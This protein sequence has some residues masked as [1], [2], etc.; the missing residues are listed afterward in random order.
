MADWNTVKYFP[1][2]MVRYEMREKIDIAFHRGMQMKRDHLAKQRRKE[3]EIL[4][5]KRDR[6]DELLKAKR[7]SED[8]IFV[9]EELERELLVRY[10]RD[11]EDRRVA[12]ERGLS[13]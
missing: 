12:N 7:D 6:E 9:Q 13:Q 3:D 8:Q 11:E 1:L 4:K 2:D 10:L 5:A